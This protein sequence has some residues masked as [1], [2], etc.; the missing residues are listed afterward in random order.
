MK[1]LRT[2]SRGLQVRYLQILLKDL[3]LYTGN[4]DGIFGNNTR[5]AV[6][7][8]QKNTTIAETGIVDDSTWNALIPYAKVPTTIAYSY[9]IMMFNIQRLILKYPFLDIGNIGLSVMKKTIPYIRLGFGSNYVLYVG[10]THA[11]EWITSTVLMKFMEDFSEAYLQDVTIEGI[12]AKEIYEST[13]IFIVPMLNPDG[14]D[15]VVND[16]D[17]LS[18]EYIEAKNISQDYPPLPF[19]SGWKANIT[20]I[21]LNLQF[22]AEWEMAREIKFGQG[23]ISPAPRDFVGDYPLQAPEALAIYDFTLSNNFNLMLTYHTQGEVIYWQ[24]LDYNPP[25]SRKIGETLSRVSGYSLEET[26]YASSF[27]GF[28][29]WFI[30]NFNR[31]GYTIEAGLGTNPLSISQFDKIYSDNVGILTY[32]ALPIDKIN[33]LIT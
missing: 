4:I 23:Y 17:T 21:D 26:P 13:S 8:F 3:N 29:D 22:P 30:Q 14:V 5:N 12:R 27:A 28:K 20:G 11:N 15:L 19:P 18:P 16:I 9:D 6:I 1:I 24:F 10:S 25:N 33:Q 7:S 32:A 2:G 31:P